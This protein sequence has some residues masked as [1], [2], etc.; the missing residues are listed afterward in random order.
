MLQKAYET[1]SEDEPGEPESKRIATEDSNSKLWGFMSEI[2]TEVDVSTGSE[3][4]Q[5]LSEPLIDLKS[6]NPYRWWKNRAVIILCSQSWP[7]NTSLTSVLHQ[8]V[9]IQNGYSQGLGKFMEIEKV[10]LRQN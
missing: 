8:Q 2:F 6:G 4:E 5:Y 3:I 1:F 7:E 10:V 9:F